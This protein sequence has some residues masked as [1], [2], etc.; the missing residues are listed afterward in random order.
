MKVGIS[1]SSSDSILLLPSSFK[2]ELK[3]SHCQNE[4]FLVKKSLRSGTWVSGLFP[5]T[6]R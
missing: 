6:G 1:N 5:L 4:E 3:W 2:A